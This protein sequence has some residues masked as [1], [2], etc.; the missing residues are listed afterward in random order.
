MSWTIEHCV[1]SALARHLGRAPFAILG[2]PFEPVLRGIGVLMVLG[3]VLDVP[4]E[5]FSPDLPRALARS[6]PG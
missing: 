6:A 5:D 2:A 1:T 4:P 3:Y